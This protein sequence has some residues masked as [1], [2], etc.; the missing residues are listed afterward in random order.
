MKWKK[1]LLRFS[2][3]MSS[4]AVLG[5]GLDYTPPGHDSQ[6]G[7]RFKKYL[8]DRFL[9]FDGHQCV[10]TLSIWGKWQKYQ[11]LWQTLAIK[12]GQNHHFSVVCSNPI[13]LL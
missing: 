3:A 12:S 1:R 8:P 5:C 9:I 13:N 10:S 2:L 4:H 6:L 11:N 7:L